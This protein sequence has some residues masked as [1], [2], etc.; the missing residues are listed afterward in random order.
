MQAR[1][2][3]LRLKACSAGLTGGIPRHN[4]ENRYRSLTY[5]TKT[6]EHLD[7]VNQ[8]NQNEK[9]ETNLQRESDD[10]IDRQ[11]ER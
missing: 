2:E 5:A 4:R 8:K 7:H 6:I 3:A 11:T 1:R 9:L 10:R